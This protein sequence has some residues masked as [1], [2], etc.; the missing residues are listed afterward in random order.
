MNT[1][2]T[3]PKL[4]REMLSRLEKGPRLSC[5]FSLVEVMVAVAIA[6][7]GIVV[8][9]Q[10]LQ[11]WEERKRTTSSGSD[12]QVTGAIAIYNLDRDIKQAGYGIGMSTYLGCTVNAYDTSR[13]TPA[14]TFPL[15]PVQ[16]IDGASGAADQIIILYGSS[17]SFVA[18]Q[19][20]TT[21]SATA[22]RT[23]VR[24]GFNKGDL[25]IVA[26]NGVGSAANCDL[27]EITS[28]TNADALTIDHAVGAYTNEYPSQS[29][30][31]RYNNPAGTGGTYSSGGLHNLGP[32][33]LLSPATLAQPR[34]N[35]WAIRTNN[36]LAWSDSLHDNATWNEV[37]EGI[38]NLQAE[39]GLDANNDNQIAAAEW[40][41][42][43]PTDWS[44]VRAIRIGLLSRSQ[45]YEKLA[46]TTTA[47]SWAG[48]SFTMTNLDG[49]AGSTAPGDDTD[50][51][52][53][54]YRVF[55]R[56]IP[57]RNVIWGT[58]P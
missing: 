55:E 17:P 2:Q 10:V 40:T 30:T 14:F 8:I 45:Q 49:S 56:V 33:N 54:R 43:T 37:A 35:T 3:F 48:G 31:A 41:T 20:F 52:H 12:A 7:I 24:S 53:Y 15:Y 44:K 51:R 47:P 42:T 19:T 6:L 18:N 26:G 39:Y 50:W 22:K 28:N 46:V 5:G 11:V 34:R 57:L 4:R 13:G 21:S 25:V 36:A 38:I 1:V 29:V 9:F 58:A 27:V 16:I 32:G 23:S